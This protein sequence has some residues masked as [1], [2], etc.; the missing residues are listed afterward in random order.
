MKKQLL[1]E[2]ISKE[3]MKKHIKDYYKYAKK[4]LDIDKAPKL[5]FVKDDKNADD[6]FGKTGF[7]EPST[8]TI[9][10]YVTNRHAKDIVRS[11]AHELIHHYQNLNERLPDETMAKTHDV[12]YASKNKDLRDME[13]EAFEKGNMMF[14]DWTDSIKKKRGKTMNEAKKRFPKKMSMDQAKK[15]G[16]PPE[17]DVSGNGSIEGWEAGRSAA[18][19][20][21]MQESEHKKLKEDPK[22]KSV[23]CSQCGGE[24]KIKD[25]KH[26]FS[27]CSDHKGL[28]NY[29]LDESLKSKTKTRKLE[30]ARDLQAADERL[31][32]VLEPQTRVLDEKFKKREEIIYN[33]LM[34]RFIKKDK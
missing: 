1:T 15:K 28:K 32:K 17:A 9:N 16:I 2:E 30:E 13:R 11:F 23:Y 31:A 8:M 25:R 33:E 20:K 21:N 34:R 12:D 26:G 27:H 14:R 4:H 19:K 10:L 22:A 7:Y 24:F 18:R 3:E 29:D 5:K 6:F